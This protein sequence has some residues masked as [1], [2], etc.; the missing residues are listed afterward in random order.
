MLFKIFTVCL[1]TVSLTTPFSALC[2]VVPIPGLR[3]SHTEHPSTMDLFY[4]APFGEFDLPQEIYDKTEEIDGDWQYVL[5]L[6]TGGIHTIIDRQQGMSLG[7]SIRM[8][9]PGP[10]GRVPTSQ[11]VN[12]QCTY[13]DIIKYFG[14]GWRI[15]Y[16][17]PCIPFDPTPATCY[18]NT[19]ELVLDHGTVPWEERAEVSISLPVQCDSPASGRVIL[20]GGA[21]RI[22]LGAGYTILCTDEGALGTTISFL[23]G[24]ST[25]TL[26]S[27]LHNVNAGMWSASS[28]LLLEL[29]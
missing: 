9:Q 27:T 8:L 5:R 19:D 12:L 18:I 6:S 24:A 29:D 25:L 2:K 13:F 16:S 1:L 21:D 15:V 23:S 20:P 4:T 7:D 28:P 26:H 11:I 10:G 3:L 22:P 17:S 14:T